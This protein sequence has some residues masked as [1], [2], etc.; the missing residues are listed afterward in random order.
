MYIADGLGMA[1]DY[2]RRLRLYSSTI[3]KLRSDNNNKIII[4]IVKFVKRHT[5]SYSPV[6]VD[7]GFFCHKLACWISIQ[8]YNGQR[9]HLQLHFTQKLKKHDMLVGDMVIACCWQQA[10]R[11]KHGCNIMM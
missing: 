10:P 4:I 6:I 3:D 8:I 11:I 9:N 5:R 1:S 7:C 2:N